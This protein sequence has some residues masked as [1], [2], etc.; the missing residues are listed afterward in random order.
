MI[1]RLSDHFVKIPGADVPDRSAQPISTAVLMFVALRHVENRVL[2][3]LRAEGY[4]VS[5]AQA[6]VAARLSEDGI[7]LTDLAAQA[8]VTKQ[9]AGQLVDQ[10]EHAGWVERVPDPTDGRA[11]LIRISE[12]GHR[13]REVARVVEREVEEEWTRHLG[14]DRWREL[15]SSLLA[16]R[17]LTDP[18]R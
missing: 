7:R 2:A 6:R 18:W 14:G 3:A 8:Q 16:L 9:T 12:L 5:L 15:R 4:D 1:V 17:E 13:A 11:R 10:L